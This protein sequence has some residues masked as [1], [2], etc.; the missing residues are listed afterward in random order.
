MNIGALLRIIIKDARGIEV[1]A[2]PKVRSLRLRS[3]RAGP[4]RDP[5]RR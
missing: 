1:R 3:D 4:G 2:E 5:R